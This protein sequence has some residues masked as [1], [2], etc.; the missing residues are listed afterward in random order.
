MEQRGSTDRPTGVIAYWRANVRWHPATFG[1]AAALALGIAFRL[2]TL[3]L[4]LDRDEGAYG[5]IGRGLLEGVV[6]YRDVFDHKPPAVYI[7]Y[8]AASAIGGDPVVAV[9]AGSA[10]LFAVT[11][12]LVFAVA[13]RVY[14]PRAGAVA[15]LAF[16][17]I[18]NDMT[19]EGARANTEQI[20]LP[21]LV[22]SLYCFLRGV[23]QMTG[24][25]ARATSWRWLCA[26]GVLGG[27]AVLTKPVAAWP[28]L[29]LALF[30]AWPRDDGNRIGFA[31][32][33]ALLAS[34]AVPI[35]AC[36]ALYAA[37]G[38]TPEFYDSVVRFNSTYVRYFW[39]NGHRGAITDFSPLA[40]PFAML[41]FASAFLA[42]ALPPGSRRVHA[43]IV[44]WTAANL[45]GA[46]MGVRTFGHYFVPVTPGIAL[47]SAAFVEAVLALTPRAASLPSWQRF[48][49]AAAAL[50]L[51]AGWQLREN[52]QFYVLDSPATRIQ[53]EFGQQ[54]PML[55]AEAGDVSSY[56]AGATSADDEILVWTAEAEVYYLADR[57]PASRYV[58]GL[59]LA[60]ASESVETLRRDFVERRPRAVVI[61]RRDGI[62]DQELI[63]RQGY[64]R[65]FTAGWFDVYEP[66]SIVTVTRP[67]ASR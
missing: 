48:A 12:L 33:L 34:A 29:C 66:S 54:G 17:L 8:A 21:A 57:K 39:D 67:S 45:V 65:T 40:S 11:L 46:K 20:M 26:A 3:R 32:P 18:G 56:L 9:R 49:P 53:R 22:G 42:F 37:L 38:A 60:F 14:G 58:Y 30:A 10:L 55:F 41:A 27:V 1:A 35:V 4:P 7:F 51:A 15:A 61:N 59:S 52:A 24:A 13:R 2:W 25:S 36:I 19:I 31:A 50:I 16:A 64:V 44:L 23:P 62:A 6:P 5:T 63:A 47:L 43:L 28:L